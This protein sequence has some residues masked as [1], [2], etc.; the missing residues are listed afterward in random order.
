MLTSFTITHT[1]F[2]ASGIPVVPPATETV[3][4]EKVTNDLTSANFIAANLN[5][6]LPRHSLKCSFKEGQQ[7]SA[8]FGTTRIYSALHLYHSV[9]TPN[10]A[11]AVIPVVFKFEASRPMSLS[12]ENSAEALEIFRAYVA[13]PTFAKQWKLEV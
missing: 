5:T 8:S 9:T 10:S 4:F 2:D 6:A 3:A 12:P 11:A 7:T 1:S 13:S